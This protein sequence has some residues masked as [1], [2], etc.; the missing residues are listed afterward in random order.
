[1][2]DTGDIER[3]FTDRLDEI[4]PEARA[5]LLHVLKLPDLERVRSIAEFHSDPRTRS[6]A[7][8]LVDIE[9]SPEAR[10]FVLSELQERGS[11][12]DS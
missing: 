3:T 10:A 5:I 11:R 6:F 4:G 12:N 2:A 8:L 9:A 1:M 7:Q